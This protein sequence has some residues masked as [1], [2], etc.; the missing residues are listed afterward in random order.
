MKRTSKTL[1]TATGIVAATL[2]GFATYVAHA[3]TTDSS[4]TKGRILAQLGVT[5][6]QK[7]EVKGILRKYQP[8]VEPMV[9]QLVDARRALR[10]TIRAETIDESAIR[11]QAA[12]VASLEA[13]LAVQR[14]HIAHD[15]RATLTPDQIEKLKELQANRDARVDA[16]LSRVAKRIS[17]D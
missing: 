10:G 5:G 17:E 2:I 15:V 16:F 8:T 11:A 14:A 3:S 12:R 7:A 1:A 9:R 13:D 4:P 6:E